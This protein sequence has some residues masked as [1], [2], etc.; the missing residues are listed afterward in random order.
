MEKTPEQC[1]IG[2]PNS[3][4]AYEGVRW[5]KHLSSGLDDWQVEGQDYSK[6]NI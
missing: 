1:C 3:Q 2:R 6:E 4:R 5:D